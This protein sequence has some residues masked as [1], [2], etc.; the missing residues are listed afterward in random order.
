MALRLLD[1]EKGLI[2]QLNRRAQQKGYRLYRNYGLARLKFKTKPVSKFTTRKEVNQYKQDINNYLRRSTH[3]Y[4]RGGLITRKGKSNMTK[5]YYY[6]IPRTELWEIRRL[7]KERNKKVKEWN[8]RFESTKIDIKGKKQDETL[9]QKIKSETA[10]RNKGL[11]GKGVL[12]KEL[13]LDTSLITSKKKLNRFKYGITHFQSKQS[14]QRKNEI[15]FNN[16]L[17]AL[18]NTFGSNARPLVNVL[19]DLTTDEFI[20]FFKSDEFAEFYDVY[21]I[22]Q[23]KQLLTNLGQHFLNF[24]DQNNIEID[25]VDRDLLESS[26]NLT[27]RR[28]ILEYGKGEY[29]GTRVFLP[30]IE[31]VST[32]KD[33]TTYYIDLTPEESEI[34]EASG[35]DI[36]TLYN[37]VGGNINA[38]KKQLSTDP[39]LRKPRRK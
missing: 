9:G 11:G 21:D 8:K 15:A 14:I 33:R 26:F 27:S 6:P 22:A 34:Y 37:I 7:I 29:G 39:K 5:Q 19:N 25:D 2:R 20:A 13:K 23:A 4:V 35:R 17:Q 3:N 16:Y 30:H 31:N 10:G 18:Y 1:K 24:I 28:I 38:R 12:F 32:T 36:N